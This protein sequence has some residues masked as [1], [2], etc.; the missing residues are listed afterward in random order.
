MIKLD[1]PEIPDEM[2][3]DLLDGTPLRDDVRRYRDGVQMFHAMQSE[4]VRKVE[5]LAAEERR[6]FH[7]I[8]LGTILISADPQAEFLSIMVQ[9]QEIR[10]QI[11]AI[12]T[13]ARC[14]KRER[15]VE[16]LTEM[17]KSLVERIEAYK[18]SLPAQKA[19]HIRILDE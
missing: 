1:V 9:V 11:A 4:D 3:K 8:K 10:D 13:G 7:D 17:H 15:F 2:L 14:Q 19:M 6:K 12:E 5:A 16:T 18:N